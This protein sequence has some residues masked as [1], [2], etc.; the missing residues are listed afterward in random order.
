MSLEPKTPF[1]PQK[2]SIQL[3]NTE[4]KKKR[5]PVATTSYASAS[6]VNEAMI[7]N[8]TVVASPNELFSP[9]GAS[10]NRKKSP[11]VSVQVAH[12]SKSNSI[13]SNNSYLNPG[14]LKQPTIIGGIER[15]KSSKLVNSVAN[16][17]VHEEPDAEEFISPDL[18]QKKT[19]FTESTVP[20]KSHRQRMIDM[21]K[22]CQLEITA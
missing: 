4:K 18:P 16:L 17:T 3:F 9:R 2:R 5:K 12:E 19:V 21:K 20:R 8:K 7:S 13:A 15:I 14:Q 11:S 1:E 6:M 10:V 22:M